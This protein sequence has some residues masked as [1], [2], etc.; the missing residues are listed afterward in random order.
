VLDT[1]QARAVM[2]G[3]IRRVM[4]TGARLNLLS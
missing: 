4:D 2:R 1:I 3:A